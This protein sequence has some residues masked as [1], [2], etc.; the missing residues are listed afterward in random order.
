MYVSNLR[1]YIEGLG[2][3]LEIA[4]T[5]PEGRVSIINFG[6]LAQ[7]PSSERPRRA[8]AQVARVIA[9]SGDCQDSGCQY[10]GNRCR[11]LPSFAA[12]VLR[13]ASEISTCASACRKSQGRRV[14]RR[15]APA[16]VRDCRARHEVFVESGAA[17]R[18]G[19]A[20]DDYA[21]CG[22]R[23]AEAPRCSPAAELIV[24]V[25]EPQAA[26]CAMLPAR[27]SSPTCIWRPIRSRP[28][29][30]ARAHGHRLRDGDG[31][32]GG[33]PLLAPMS[34]VAGRMSIQAGAHCLEMEQ[35]GRGMLLGGVAGVAPARRRDRRRRV[36]ANAARMAV[37]LEADVTV[38]DITSTGSTSSTSC[39][40]P[41]SR[42]SSPRARPSRTTCSGR[43]R[44][45]RGAGAGRRGAQAHHRAAGQ[46]DEARLGHRRCRHRSGRLLETSQPTT[47]ANPTY[48]CTTS[49]TTASP[50]CRARCRAP[51]PSRS[52]TRRCPSCWRLPTR[53]RRRHGAGPA[54]A[55]RSQR[56]Q[57]PHLAPRR[58]HGAGPSPHRPAQAAEGLTQETPGGTGGTPGR[59]RRP[60]ADGRCPCATINRRLPRLNERK[61]AESREGAEKYSTRS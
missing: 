4:A 27:R 16:S 44:R 60:H 15:H 8:K 7:D 38:L 20:D 57:G 22:R 43:S 55:R 37:G 1:R 12:R 49:C 48:V 47:H 40:A 36:G 29:P 54:L 24:K 9:A 6:D 21:A 33:L 3:S 11:Q 19:I 14:P 56:L 50:T 17:A 41:P 34:E 46:R 31:A 58:R 53:A 35:G 30:E 59:A 61:P 51:R 25:K 52:T 28:G 39:S 45:R 10:P 5:F 2:G 26:E 18:L 32:R 23:P 13:P 42:P